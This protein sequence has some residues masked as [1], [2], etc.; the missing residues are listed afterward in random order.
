MVNSV[1]F[2]VA[3]VIVVC[4]T[5]PA[6]VAAE[7]DNPEMLTHVDQNRPPKSLLSLAKG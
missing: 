7:S 4:P 1:V 3:V 2:V 5:H 6:L